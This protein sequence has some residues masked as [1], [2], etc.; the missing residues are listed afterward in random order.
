MGAIIFQKLFW[1]Q[2]K[3]HLNRCKITQKHVILLIKRN[4]L[5]PFF[6]FS[7]ERVHSIQFTLD[8]LPGTFV[9]TRLKRAAGAWRL[10]FHKPV[11]PVSLEHH[12]KKKSNK[13]TCR[14]DNNMETDLAFVMSPIITAQRAR[15][16]RRAGVWAWLLMRRLCGFTLVRPAMTALWKQCS[17]WSQTPPC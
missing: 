16:C 2:K 10:S 17:W 15:V 12:K 11:W 7:S 13:I 9:C 1:N 3:K 8:S 5:S 14:A 6:F 4:N